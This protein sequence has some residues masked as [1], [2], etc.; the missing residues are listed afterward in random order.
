M[1]SSQE[2]NDLITKLNLVP[3]S[4]ISLQ[5]VEFGASPVSAESSLVSLNGDSTKAPLSSA[6]R[7][8]ILRQRRQAY[9]RVR[10]DWLASLYENH[11]LGRN[12]GRK[13][14]RRVDQADQINPATKEDYDSHVDKAEVASRGTIGSIQYKEIPKKAKQNH[15]RKS[16]INS[17]PSDE[18]S[19]DDSKHNTL[20]QI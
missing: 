3:G 4:V 7:S 8:A 11:R 12:E 14:K 20:A 5:P 2:N 10:E 9:M 17:S 19:S 15:H 13:R 1:A 18:R 6:E 16:D